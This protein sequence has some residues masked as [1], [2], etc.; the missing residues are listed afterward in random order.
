MKWLSVAVL[1]GVA[2]YVL[3]AL[4]S[5]WLPTNYIFD[6]K[7]LNEICNE[8]LSRHDS[9][10]E[11]YSTEALLRDVRDA[12][13]QHYGDKY[14]NRY[15]NDD[16][17]FNNAGGAMGQ[18][19]ILHASL[20]E[21]VILF[22]SAVGTEGHT[23]VHFADDYFTILHGKQVAA[24]PHAANPEVY[25]PGMTHH[26]ERGYA[27]QYAMPSGSFALELAQGWIPCMLP[28]GFLDTF[29]STLDLYTLGKTVYLTGKDM[30]KNLVKNGKF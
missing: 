25:L 4:Y 9:S 6:A 22:G 7:T 3:N 11:N 13:A 14:I 23:G 21:Y 24:L 27:K 1:L 10:S 28:F 26:L 12:L 18:M 20:S 2:A 17:V 8:V 19:I 16:W 30:A 5:T 15:A 29:S